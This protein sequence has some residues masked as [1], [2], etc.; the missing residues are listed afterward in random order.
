ME[1]EVEESVEVVV[2]TGV[3]SNSM[4]HKYL[5]LK[6][7]VLRLYVEKI[8]KNVSVRGNSVSITSLGQAILVKLLE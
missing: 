5:E 3:I 7:A 8:P 2:G 1:L 6:S 4:N